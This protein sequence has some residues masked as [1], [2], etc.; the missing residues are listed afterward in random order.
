[1]AWSASKRRCRWCEGWTD[2]PESEPVSHPLPQAMDDTAHIG[3][4][5]P[6]IGPQSLG[7][8]EIVAHHTCWMQIRAVLETVQA[9]SRGDNADFQPPGPGTVVLMV[10]RQAHGQEIAQVHLGRMP[11]DQVT[12]GARIA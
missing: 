5:A 1:M 10:V 12:A 3:F 8:V 4:E 7:P 6:P 11:A 2:R 9:R